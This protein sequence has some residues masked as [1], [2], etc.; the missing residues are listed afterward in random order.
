ML[1]LAII[2]TSALVQPAPPAWRPLPL[3]SIAP[4]GWLLDQLILQANSLSGFMPISTFPGAKSVNISTWF[5]GKGRDGLTQWAPYWT[6]GNVPLMMLLRAA[7]PAALARLDPAANLGAVIDGMMAYVLAHTNATNGWIGPFANEP[8]DFNGHGLWDPL[9][10]VRSLLMYAEA[11]PKVR[12]A[13]AA[14]VVRHL[15]TEARLVGTDPVYKWAST[16]WPT[17]VQICMYVIDYY[18]PSYGHDTQVMPLGGPGTIAMLL[19]T[20]CVWVATRGTLRSQH[21][22]G[23]GF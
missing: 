19:I 16:R 23:T 17:F 18:V 1:C 14:A 4:T 10:M 7:G 21:M 20:A 15:T 22:K 13:V 11:T 5:G 3:G 2:S 6:N 8:G 9:N 12:R